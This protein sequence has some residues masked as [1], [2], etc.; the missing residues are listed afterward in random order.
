MT[1]R[2]TRKGDNQ[3]ASLYGRFIRSLSFTLVTHQTRIATPKTSRSG[4]S[5]GKCRTEAIKTLQPLDIKGSDFGIARTTSLKSKK[6]TIGL[7]VNSAVQA[8]T[9]GYLAKN[10]P[11]LSHTRQSGMGNVFGIR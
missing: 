7:G 4:S 5:S 3:S 1:T 10:A 9:L 8:G 11:N 6:G 2:R